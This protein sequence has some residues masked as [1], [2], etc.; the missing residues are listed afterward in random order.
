VHELLSI[1]ISL[2]GEE[3]RGVHV[4]VCVCK[5][6]VRYGGEG[7]LFEVVDVGSEYSTCLFRVLS[8]CIVSVMF[9]CY[10]CIMFV[11]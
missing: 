1:L 6:Q 10:L 7:D 5:S 11:C 9:V 3:G 2:L 4:C 8:L